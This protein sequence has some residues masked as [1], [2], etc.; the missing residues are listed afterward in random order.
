MSKSAMLLAEKFDFLKMKFE[1]ETPSLSNQLSFA[2]P[3][4]LLLL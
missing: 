3:P 1:T 2:D 4:K